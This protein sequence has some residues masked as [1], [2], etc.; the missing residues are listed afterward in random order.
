[1]KVSCPNS[2]SLFEQSKKMVPGGVHSP[3][4]AF[5][6]VGGTPRFIRSA[7]GVQL[8]DVD[9][10]RYLDFCMS[11]GPLIFGH[12][13]PEIRSAVEDALKRGWSYGTAEPYSLELAQ[14]ITG[15]LPWVEKIRFVN[16]GTEA[17]MAALRVARAATGRNKI[18][19][20]E[21]CYHGHVDSMLVK[22]GSG[23]AD[24]ASPDSAGVSSAVA[25]D[26]IVVPLNDEPRLLAALDRHGHE[27]AAVIVEPI[28]ANNGLLLQPDDFLPR[29][30][31][32]AKSAGS[33]L[34]FDE[35]IT[36]FR[37]AFGGMA[38]R[39]GVTPDLVTYGKII[40]GG[41]PVGA[42]GG[43]ADLMEWVAPLG[44]VYQA[45]TLSA[46]PVAMTAGV[47]TLKKLRQENPYPELERKTQQL[48]SRI[49]QVCQEMD[50]QAHVQNCASL[51]WMVLGQRLNSSETV[52]DLTQV[53][54]T[55]KSRYA[56]LF[57]ALL[58]QGIYLA[59]SA[60]EVSFLSTAHQEAHMEQFLTAFRRSLETIKPE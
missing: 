32:L 57:H 46:N 9:G 14:L 37:V 28:P 39:S 4:R 42:Y 40:G 19:K 1:M 55:H 48:C 5:R 16:S 12:Q 17:V 11:W 50:F 54:E 13:H 15:S 52:R 20:F 38:E 2:E 29:L 34:I 27:I 59:P 10:N 45:G 51:F 8:E 21:G 3:V 18:L 33:L 25:S 49:Q 22:A 7:S 53:P 31:A 56:T 6:G 43:R 23:L 24:M 47:A 41:F 35:V 58:A 60:C 30:A 36:G 44:P 26:T